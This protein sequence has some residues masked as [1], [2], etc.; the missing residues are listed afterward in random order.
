MCATATEI[1]VDIYSEVDCSKNAEVGM[2]L[3]GKL[4]DLGSNAISST[5]THCDQSQRVGRVVLTP[6]GDND[7]EIAFEVI[8]R[9]DDQGLET[10]N[11]A[12]NYKGCIVARRQLHFSPH[13]ALKLRVDL[14]LA[15]LDQTCDSTSTCVAGGCV[16][17]VCPT[18]GCQ[19][20]TVLTT[21]NDS[22]TPPVDSGIADVVT[23]DVPVITNPLD[24]STICVPA[25]VSG[26]LIVGK[27]ATTSAMIPTG[28]ATQNHLVFAENDCRY[29]YFWVDDPGTQL[30]TATSTDLVSWTPATPIP[31]QGLATTDPLAGGIGANF[32]V[33]YAK[34]GP[35][36]TFH[37]VISQPTSD[38]QS[39]TDTGYPWD[40]R[41][42]LVNGAPATITTSQIVPS[43]FGVK[44]GQ[45]AN[46]DGPSIAIGPANHVYISSG[47]YYELGRGT[48]CDNSIY[49]SEPAE[50]T[51]A[52]ANTWG[53]GA[54]FD[55]R[56]YWTGTPEGTSSHLLLPIANINA[57]Y[58]AYPEPA[59]NGMTFYFSN[60]AILHDPLN[61]S[62]T[63]GDGKV[64]P[65]FT[66]TAA[67][68]LF[69]NG[70]PSGGNDWN[71]CISSALA[72]HALRRT[73]SGAF[74]A[75]T[76]V[77]TTWQAETQAPG[78]L[79]VTDSLYDN[80][81][82]DGIVMMSD[83]DPTHPMLAF[84]IGSPGNLYYTKYTGSAINSADKK[85]QP[86][87]TAVTLQNGNPVTNA[88]FLA[89]SGCSSSRPTLFWSDLPGANSPVIHSLDVSSLY[90]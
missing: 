70:L 79:A 63:Y 36:D 51:T 6:S 57:V 76:Q 42:V 46:T 15:C 72:G 75:Q 16:S 83:L 5:T 30:F 59:V 89:G 2:I 33:A 84:A 32:S 54:K 80:E 69:Q 14:R 20:E 7:E 60:A 88:T 35:V 18:G 73:H 40:V 53:N 86:Q 21:P 17:A 24:A 8:T 22:G 81:V 56:G 25:P 3:G 29:W 61:W 41:F 87:W 34:V 26:G 50:D 38:A 1:D 27:V 48:R 64:Q 43:G 58:S 77:G 23:A 39:G 55:W 65:P 12:S 13:T 9:D 74:E 85:W 66:G 28:L 44:G 82:G 49:V 71:V 19:S 78:P 4:T 10:C 62:G 52:T 37:V 47:W 11:A 31:L 90:K 67:N 45:C 68:Q